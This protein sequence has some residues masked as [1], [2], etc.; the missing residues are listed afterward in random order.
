MRILCVRSLFEALYM[1]IYVCEHILGGPYFNGEH[2]SIMVYCISHNASS[3]LAKPIY[4]GV[5]I[6]SK[7]S[8]YVFLH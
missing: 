6:C 3:G 7:A 5:S 8:I 4:F 1:G 2:V